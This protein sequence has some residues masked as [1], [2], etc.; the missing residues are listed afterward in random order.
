MQDNG[1]V[2]DIAELGPS[3]NGWQPQGLSPCPVLFIYSYKKNAVLYCIFAGK[4]SVLWRNDVPV[5]WKYGLAW[6]LC[7]GLTPH[8]GTVL[9]LVFYT[10]LP[11]IAVNSG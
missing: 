7:M 2:L 10:A 5:L 1:K 4:S 9:L 3:F 6:V 11:R 8:A